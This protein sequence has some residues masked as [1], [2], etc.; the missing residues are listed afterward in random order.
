MDG[1]NVCKKE[2]NKCRKK[3]IA[4][5][6]IWIKQSERKEK[7]KNISY[8]ETKNDFTKVHILDKRGMFGYRKGVFQIN[9]EY[10]KMYVHK[11]RDVYICKYC[12]PE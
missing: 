3:L 6:L 2:I 12:L 9:N 4:S 11:H 5:I 10:G 8:V 7:K 1:E